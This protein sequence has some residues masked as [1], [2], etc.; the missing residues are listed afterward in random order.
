M[1][2]KL[3]Q[4]IRKNWLRYLWWTPLVVVWKLF[5]ARALGRANEWIDR[6]TSPLIDQNTDLLMEVLDGVADWAPLVTWVIM[7]VLVVAFL[8]R[9]LYNIKKEVWPSSG[10][11]E[12]ATGTYFS[13]AQRLRLP[14]QTGTAFITDEYGTR[15]QRTFDLQ[16]LF[17]LH[18]LLR[19]AVNE[20]TLTTQERFDMIRTAFNERGWP[21]AQFPYTVEQFAANFDIH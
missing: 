9:A 4:W 16:G 1:F 11:Q 6:N 10:A 8:F 5:E 3:L 15:T 14:V 2:G 19:D 21:N 12:L 20:A 17:D 18:P 13:G 7:G